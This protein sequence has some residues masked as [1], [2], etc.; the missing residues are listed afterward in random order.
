[1][2][3][4]TNGHI[5]NLSSIH[6]IHASTNASAYCASKYAV[7]GLTEALSQNSGRMAS[8][9]LLFALAAY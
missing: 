7:T 4:S 1:M 5:V 9:F 3:A 6:G 8:K 2:I